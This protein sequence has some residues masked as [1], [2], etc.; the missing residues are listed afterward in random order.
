MPHCFDDVARSGLALGANHSRSLADTPQRLAKVARPAH[1]WNGEEMLIDMETFIRRGQHL[2][3]IDAI[4]TDGLENFSLDKMPNAALRHHR[5]SNRLF[6]LNNEFGVAHARDA[7]VRANIR[8][9]ALQCHHRGCSGLFRD[10][11]LV[12]V[13]HIADHSALEHLRESA[14]DIYCSCLFLHNQWSPG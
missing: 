8:R 2:G 10:T 5:N 3:L 11:R 1:K 14:L 13:H 7:T 4:Y 12:R 6:N 9:H